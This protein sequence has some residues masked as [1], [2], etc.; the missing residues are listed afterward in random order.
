MIA[1]PAFAYFAH[2]HALFEAMDI[3]KPLA[4]S[5]KAHGNQDGVYFSVW[6]SGETE[7]RTLHDMK[8][9]IHTTMDIS[10]GKDTMRVRMK[11]LGYQSRYYMS[12]TD[13]DGT[14]VT[15]HDREEIAQ[16]LGKWISIPLGDDEYNQA[17]QQHDIKGLDDL[18]TLEHTRVPGGYVYSLKLTNP[19]MNALL[20][21][22]KPFYGVEDF[23]FLEG[24]TPV[25]FHMKVDTDDNYHVRFVRAHLSTHDL[26]SDAA[27]SIEGEM[28]RKMTPVYLAVPTDV[29]EVEDIL[30]SLY[31]STMHCTQDDES[32]GNADWSNEDW[33]EEIWEEEW[34]EPHFGDINFETDDTI[35][36]PGEGFVRELRRSRRR[37]NY[38][39]D[40]VPGYRTHDLARTITQRRKQQFMEAPGTPFEYE[41]FV[42]GRSG[43]TRPTRRFSGRNFRDQRYRKHV[44]QIQRDKEI[45]ARRVYGKSP[46]QE[47]E[48][49]DADLKWWDGQ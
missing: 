2:P 15:D 19:G 8:N 36:P 21:M 1:Q 33:D 29:I 4:F 17:M 27:F 18:F 3:G 35:D 46:V 7:G 47:G 9:K 20:S 48:L 41:D 5:G 30:T 49:R 6:F 40:H 45:A 23:V 26:Q 44:L 10:D 34:E 12:I 38:L 11:F 31:C 14:I 13:I 28:K 42:R 43:Y 25:N 16:M 32:W 24:R 39:H 22:L 37:D